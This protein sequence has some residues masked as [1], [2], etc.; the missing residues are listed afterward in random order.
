MALPV[1]DGAAGPVEVGPFLVVDCSTS[2]L[3]KNVVAAGLLCS[4]RPVQSFAL[5]VGALERSS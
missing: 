1:R 5:H 3:S 4:G 2:N